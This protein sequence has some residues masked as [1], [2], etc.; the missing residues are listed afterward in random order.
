MLGFSTVTASA[1]DPEPS[2]ATTDA[3]HLELHGSIG[4]VEDE[5][6]DGE[7]RVLGF[8]AVTASAE[9][10]EPSTTTTS[11]A[12][13]TDAQRLELK[14]RIGLLDLEI[15][16]LRLQGGLGS[17]ALEI[18][19]HSRSRVLLLDERRALNPCAYDELFPLDRRIAFLDLQLDG[20]RIQDLMIQKER[21]EGIMCSI[22]AL[23]RS[24]TVL[25]T[26]LWTLSLFDFVDRSG[27]AIPD[28][29]LNEF[30]ICCPFGPPVFGDDLLQRFAGRYDYKTPR[31]SRNDSRGRALY[32]YCRSFLIPGCPA[33]DDLDI[34]DG[35]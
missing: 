18:D 11:P 35:P 28:E 29:L 19:V 5:E 22:N 17:I 15:S 12:T 20:L 2:S 33:S 26:E 4:S 34:W 1:E 16:D 32:F 25:V 6:A 14:R 31:K 7:A 27:P 23:S 30:L 9:D 3:A 21:A 10:P 24:R 13:D 8:S